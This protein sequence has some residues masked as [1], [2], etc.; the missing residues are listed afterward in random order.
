MLKNQYGVFQLL[1]VSSI[2]YV[3]YLRYFF[4]SNNFQSIHKNVVVFTGGGQHD[5]ERSDRGEEDL[6]GEHERPRGR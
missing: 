5:P 1:D 4:Q 6:H 3:I 2:Q